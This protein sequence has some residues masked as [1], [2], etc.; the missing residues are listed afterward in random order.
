M[1]NKKKLFLSIFIAVIIIL[2]YAVFVN[3]CIA[4]LIKN[5]SSFLAAGIIQAVARLV[6]SVILWILIN[7]LF[8]IKIKIKKAGFIK[9]FLWY[10]FILII[11]VLFQLAGNYQ[12]PEKNFL[13]ALPMIVYFFI[14]T[15]AIGMYEE[16]LCRGLLFNSFENYFGDTKKGIYISA[17]FSSLVFG[18]MHLMNLIWSPSLIISTTCQVIY[19]TFVG[20]LF[21]VIYYRSKNLISCMLLHGIFDF[22]AYFWF[23]F[24]DNLFQQTLDSNS[25]DISIGNG[26][27]LILLSSTFVISG[28]LQLRKE[29]SNKTLDMKK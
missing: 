5:K 13:E 19:A 21:C 3:V 27:L 26:V 29:F 9:G 10:G 25:V 24:S 11:A 14:V 16:L 4:P 15:L 23:A 1:G 2:F 17:I 20:F 22:T 7:R 8:N 12:P 6:L 18:I 28:I